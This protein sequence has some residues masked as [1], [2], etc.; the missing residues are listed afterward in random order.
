M[1]EN[2]ILLNINEDKIVRGING[3][4]DYDEQG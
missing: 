2:K 1:Y 4:D 3:M